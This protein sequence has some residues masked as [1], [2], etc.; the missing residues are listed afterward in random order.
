MKKYARLLKI[1]VRTN[2]FHKK[3]LLMREAYVYQ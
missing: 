1:K 3:Y 2:F